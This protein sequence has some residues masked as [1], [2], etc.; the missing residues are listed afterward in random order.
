MMRYATT[1]KSHVKLSISLREVF[2][3]GHLISIIYVQLRVLLMP[4]RKFKKSN[5][6]QMILLTR[7]QNYYGVLIPADQ[8]R[9]E[10][11]FTLKHKLE[12]QPRILEFWIQMLHTS[13]K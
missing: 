6:G 8:M 7:S 13:V 9:K 11:D 3:N 5:S 2:K 1:E 10:K 12:I 4:M